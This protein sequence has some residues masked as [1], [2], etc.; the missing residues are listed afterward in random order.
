M[1]CERHLVVLPPQKKAF[2]KLLVVQKG[3]LLQN[4]I[5][6]KVI[7]FFQV[8]TTKDNAIHTRHELF[9]S[10]HLISDTMPTLKCI[11]YQTCWIPEKKYTFLTLQVHTINK[12]D[13]QSNW[14]KISQ[15][16][17][18]LECLGKL[19]CSIRLTFSRTKKL[20]FK[21]NAYF[22][23]STYQKHHLN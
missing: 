20:K 9:F 17:L 7:L 19:K 16:I 23:T 13:I 2:V 14:A 12:E 3:A 8:W 11:I 4:S 10:S 21:Q 6:P 18:S 22:L 15:L 5:L 1:A